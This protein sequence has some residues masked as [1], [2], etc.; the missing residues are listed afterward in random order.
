MKEEITVSKLGLQIARA[1]PAFVFLDSTPFAPLCIY[2]V[3]ACNPLR[4]APS[5]RTKDLCS[6][7]L[8]RLDFTP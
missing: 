8:Y 5:P 4:V 3:A 7:R 2:V 6:T 1:K